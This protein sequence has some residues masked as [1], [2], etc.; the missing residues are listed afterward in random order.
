MN[1]SEHTM[2]SGSS[3]RHAE[4]YGEI[5]RGILPCMEE[6]HL[7]EYAIVTP[8]QQPIVVRDHLHHFSSCKGDERWRLV[9]QHL[10]ELLPVVPDDLDLVMTTGEQLLWVLV[11]AILVESLG[12]TKTCGIFQSYGQLQIFLLAFPDTF[13][14]GINMRRDRQWLRTWGVARPRSLDMSVFTASSRIEV[15][16]H[17]KLVE[18]WC[19]MVTIIG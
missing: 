6:I 5:Q 18:T 3:Q 12:L 2:R 19:M 14:I 9:E 16:R 15:D 8:L 11:D 7:G 10:E 17:R 13:I 4:M 1:M